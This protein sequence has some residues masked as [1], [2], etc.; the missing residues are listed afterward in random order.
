MTERTGHRAF[1]LIE[2]LVAI[3]VVALLLG[4][5]VPA[6][7][8]ARGRAQSIMCMSNLR[9]LGA[10][11]AMYAGE[12]DGLA[13]PLAYTNPIQLNGGPAIY[14][15]GTNDAGDVDHEAG[16][17]APYL[18]AALREGSVF[19]CPAQPWGSYEPQGAANS[20]TSTYGY[21]GYY[22]SPAATPGWANFIGKRPWQR[23]ASVRRP[24]DVFLFAD[25][26]LAGDPPSNNALLDPPMLYFGSAAGWQP[27]AYPTTCFRHAGAAVGGHADGSARAHNASPHDLVHP[28]GGIGSVGDDPGR[29]YI[30]DWERW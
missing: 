14:W 20:I 17:I 23:I 8:G 15:W 9:Q 25:T 21:N 4:V 3:G 13:M 19:E 29:H 11:W 27:N 22:L 10:G 5:L 12:W 18:E 6:L 24:S 30:P 26:L 28:E 2:L 1:T 7:A 16:F